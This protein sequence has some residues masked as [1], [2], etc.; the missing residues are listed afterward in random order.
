MKTVS[1]ELQTGDAAPAFSAL[2]ENGKTW[3]R[4]ALLVDE[5]KKL[6]K[7]RKIKVA[8]HIKSILEAV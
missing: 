7:M 1:A 3:S 6:C 5:G 8:G 2:D 4:P